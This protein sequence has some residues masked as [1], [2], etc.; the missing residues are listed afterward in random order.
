MGGYAII[1]HPIPLY[2]VI[3]LP[4]SKIPGEP[5][6]SSG[7]ALNFALTV[8]GSMKRMLVIYDFDW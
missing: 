8:P 4:F 1:S 2:H 7:W 3:S 5:K 6:K